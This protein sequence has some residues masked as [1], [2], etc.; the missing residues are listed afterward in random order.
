L[1]I[2][3]LGDGKLKPPVSKTFLLDDAN[4]GLECLRMGV[5]GRVVVRV[6]PE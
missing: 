2:R 4:T 3:F 6:C 1:A 5:L